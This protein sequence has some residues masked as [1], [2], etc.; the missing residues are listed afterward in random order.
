MY[1]RLAGCVL[2]GGCSLIYNT[3]NIPHPQPDAMIDAPLVATAL[4]VK[5]VSPL[6]IDEGQGDGGSRPAVLVL[7]GENFVPGAQVVISS[8]ASIS[9]MQATPSHDGTLL[10]VPV[11]AH[12]DPAGENTM[13]TLSVQV[14]QPDGMGGTVTQPLTGMPPT[15]YAHD[16]LTT[17]APTPG[18]LYSKVELSGS[19]TLPAGTASPYVL[20][21]VSSVTVGAITANGGDASTTSGGMGGAGATAG[22]AQAQDGGGAGGGKKGS[23]GSSGLL[24]GLGGDGGGGGF[25]TAGVAGGDNGGGAAG[26][27]NGDDGI[28]SYM[29]NTPSGGGGGGHF[30]GLAG[31][32]GNGGG[33]GGGGGIVELTAGGDLTCGAINN[34]GGTGAPGGSGNGGGGGGGGAGGVIVLRAGGVLTSGTLTATGGTGGAASGGGAGTGGAGSVGRIR[35]DNAG[36]TSVTASPAAV[37]G[38]AF[39]STSVITRSQI[40]S[41]VGGPGKTLTPYINGTAAADIA[42]DGSTGSADVMLP[43]VAG[44]NEVCVVVAGG[45]LKHDASSECIG[46]AY[47]P[48]P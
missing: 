20:R 36:A 48:G 47:L 40:V 26:V 43:L 15:L 18:Q 41:L 25:A 24:G 6:R 46:L 32:P 39:V 34:T 35:W 44:Y 17:G 27:M 16:E 30:A 21:A 3:G 12:V 1:R 42:L 37:R 13:I 45:T 33:G 19:I 28:S 14:T 5:D 10:A 11:T 38:P 9:V 2:V 7:H 8:P 29:A 31:M 23:D 4:S 22:G